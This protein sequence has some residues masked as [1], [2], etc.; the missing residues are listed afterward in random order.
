M[1]RHLDQKAAQTG[2]LRDVAGD[3]RRIG[4]LIAYLVKESSDIP[5]FQK[6]E[7]MSVIQAIRQVMGFGYQDTGDR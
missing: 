3:E 6:F 1:A 4:M 5:G 7:W 2:R